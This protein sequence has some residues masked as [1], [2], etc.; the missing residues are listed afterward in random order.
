M[1]IPGL[2]SNGSLENTIEDLDLRFNE[3]FESHLLGN[4]LYYTTCLCTSCLCYT[5]CFHYTIFSDYP[6]DPINNSCSLPDFRKLFDLS[7]ST[8]IENL[9]HRIKRCRIRSSAQDYVVPILLLN[10]V[11]SFISA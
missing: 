4:G 3:L 5:T 9:F 10:M 1:V 2:F 11:E 8:N 6:P 7:F